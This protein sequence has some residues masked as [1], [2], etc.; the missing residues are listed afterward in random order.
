MSKKKVLFISNIEVPYRVVFF[1]ELS[2]KCD[3]TVLYERKESKNRNRKWASSIDQ[4]YKAEYLNGINIK[5]EN[6]FDIK[7]LKYLFKKYDFIIIGCINS[8][9]Q[10]YMVLIMILFRVKYYINLDGECYISNKSFKN[11]I[12]KFLL[13]KA[14]GIFVAGEKNK[15]DL[16]RIFNNKIYTYYFSSLTKHEI[17]ENGLKYLENNRDDFILVIGQYLS[18]KGLDIIVEVAK[19]MSNQTFKIVGVG[20]KDKSFFKLLEMS[21]VKNIIVIPFLQKDDLE[22]EMKKC[23]LFVLPSR[24]ECWG[25]VINE[26][27]SFGTPIV[28]T[29]GSGA[30]VEFLEEEYPQF[31]AI[32][33]NKKDL[34]EKINNWMKL[35]IQKKEK[36]KKFLITKS[37]NYSIDK[38]VN[39]FLS[40]FN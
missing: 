6:S 8:Y 3:L 38:A 23:K 14:E 13:D 34:I 40:I 24:K 22:I 7:I 35:D 29:Y 16:E 20:N 19:E 30:A 1:N 17:A 18:Y 11:S 26:V 4:N 28:S 2:K 9:V 12:K 27:A 31:L 36:Y 25:L 5:N 10:I 33:G 15:K 39:V 32:P 21:N 37:S